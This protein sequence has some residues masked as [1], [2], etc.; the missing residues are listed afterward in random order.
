MVV[1]QFVRGV[2]VAETVA[3]SCHNAGHVHRVDAKAAHMTGPEATDMSAANDAHMSAPEA[4][5]HVTAAEAA[6]A[7][8][9]SGTTGCRYPDHH[10]CGDRGNSSVSLSFHDH[11]LFSNNHS[12]G[13]F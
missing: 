13:C 4:T 2:S 7:T 9:K 6:T 1:S 11:L 12:F 5:A 3:A 8:R 10:S